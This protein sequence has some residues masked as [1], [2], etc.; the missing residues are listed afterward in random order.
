M[1]IRHCARPAC[2]A[3]LVARPGEGPA[4]F[5]GRRYCSHGCATA[6]RR[7]V[8][9]P[10]PKVCERA[11]CGAELAERPDEGPA[12]FARRRYCSHACA[13]AARREAGLCRAGL[14][15]LTPENAGDNGHGSRYCRA[16][17]RRRE[18]EANAARPRERVSREVRPYRPAVRLP[19]PPPEQ[20]REVWR[21]A[22][23]GGPREVA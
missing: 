21:P 4:K 6:A 16:C 2:G 5:A 18:N 12:V 9:P 15:E 14:H 23:W 17:R 20:P 22:S 8:E 11:A 3:E 13:H 7:T 10:G 19:A 1:E